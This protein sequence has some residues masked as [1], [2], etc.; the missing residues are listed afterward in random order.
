[1]PPPS[2]VQYAH[3]LSGP[4]QGDV[5]TE[6]ALLSALREDAPAWVHLDGKQEGADAWIASHLDY[7]DP[8]AIEALLDVD[9]R[10]RLTVL[11]GGMILI[12]RG[13]NFNAGEDPEDM[14]SVRMWI[15]AHRIVTIS[16]KRVRAIERMNE[17]LTAD[18]GPQDAGAFLV[19]LV[20][21]VTENIGSFQKDLDLRA[22]E[23]EHKVIS[24]SSEHLRRQVVELRLQVIAS[25]RFLGPQRDAL[26]RIADAGLDFVD[27]TTRREIEEE[28]LKMT[29]IVEDMDELRDQA[30][31][32]REELSGQL[33]D[34][35]NRNMFI[36]SVLSAIFLPLG[37]LTGLFGV[38]VA[39]LPG[40]DH[41]QA[42]WILCGAMGGL[43]L[44]QLLLLWRMRWIGKGG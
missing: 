26:G 25:K 21:D 8:Q 14:V 4:S 36:L 38:N 28:H 1:M 42:F 34:R 18:Q 11:G 24:E 17:A 43:V 5:L 9:T 3:A 39:G 40:L 23:L 35:L 12:L 6:T 27:Q 2:F 7:L 37:F 29:R 31:V 33:S 10:P 16:R 30:A 15:D 41:P 32:L 44:L 13:M 22:E 19:K 20:E